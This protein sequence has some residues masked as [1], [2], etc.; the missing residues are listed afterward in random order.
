MFRWFAGTMPWKQIRFGSIRTKRAQ[1]ML[2]AERSVLFAI[3]LGLQLSPQSLSAQV[4]DAIFGKWS[5]SSDKKTCEIPVGSSPDVATLYQISAK[6]LFFYEIDCA[7]RDVSFHDGSADFD[8]DCFKGGGAA[9]W[10]E[11]VSVRPSG[12][13]RVILSFSNRKPPLGRDT[14]IE[15]LYRCPAEKM[16]EPPISKAIIS[17]W[18]HNGSIMSMSEEQGSLEIAY[19]QP[20]PGMSAVGV[21]A[22]TTLFL[23]QRDGDQVEGT[24]YLFNPNCGPLGYQVKGQ[25]LNGR[26]TLLLSGMSPRISR[27][28][29][30]AKEVSEALRFERFP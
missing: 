5:D 16:A 30:I 15:T 26:N 24:A 10:F 19:V 27:G 8:L 12:A 11:K 28:C 18:K 4:P 3:I 21:R 20:R 9:R 7:A 13:N 1:P 2:P 22:D 17:Q 25:F 29:E 6:G 23:G 14:R